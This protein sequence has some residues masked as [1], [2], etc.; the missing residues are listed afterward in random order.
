MLSA[1]LIIFGAYL[2]GSL[3]S[4]V[5]VSRLMGLPDPRLEGSRNPGA[6]N[7]LRLGGR[8]AA[9]LTLFGDFLKGLIPVLIAQSL[10][11][12][13]AV[14]VGAGLAAFLG[15]LYPVFFA[16][17]GGKGMATAFGA[18]TGLAWP[19]A[20]AMAATW[21]AV[22]VLTRYASLASLLSALLVP[23]YAWLLTGSMTLACG[24]AAM[25]V[26]LTWRHRANIGR[27][28]NGTESRI[29]N[30]S[31]ASASGSTSGSANETANG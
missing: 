29:G 3:A 1:I 8:K 31:G 12:S 9:L 23:V 2:A 25:S 4:A 17:Q 10:D 30:R 16:F 20:A 24:L 7:V 11:A 15:H 14:V 22:A 6:T 21:L 19:V 28:A 13:T 5:I 18:V 27:L 26:L